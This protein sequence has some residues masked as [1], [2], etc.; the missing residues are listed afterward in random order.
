MKDNLKQKRRNYSDIF[1]LT[2][3]MSMCC[4]E[5]VYLIKKTLKSYAK[6]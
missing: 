4:I 5:R 3:K 6:S 1:N 2:I